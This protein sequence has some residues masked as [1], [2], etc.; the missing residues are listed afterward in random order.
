MASRVDANSRRPR[1]GR[2]G[3]ASK[4]GRRT[5]LAG[6]RIQ[7]NAERP[8]RA[9]IP[10]TCTHRGRP[11]AAPAVRNAPGPRSGPSVR[12]R[13]HRP[14]HE[15]P[16]RFERVPPAVVNSRP[17]ECLAAAR[18][19]VA[20]P[21]AH[22]APAALPPSTGRRWG[23]SRVRFRKRTTE[24]HRIRHAAS[25]TASESPPA[26]ASGGSLAPGPSR[27]QEAAARNGERAGRLAFQ[28]GEEPR[29][30]GFNVASRARATCRS[31]RTSTGPS[32]STTRV[33]PNR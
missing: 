19:G 1:L 4:A 16:R 3:A 22:A 17:K 15:G 7:A 21:P 5:R 20:S 31:P 6:R 11:L 24:C 2:S 8:E 33:E 13:G 27:S 14:G 18:R 28:G 29:Q 30:L 10:P 25:T 26:A 9:T 32:F 12:F 23:S